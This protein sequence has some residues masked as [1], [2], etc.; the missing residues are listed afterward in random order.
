ME[1]H[2]H[3]PS[4][5]HLREPLSVTKTHEWMMGWDLLELQET[6]GGSGQCMSYSHP[7]YVALSL[8]GTG[9]SASFQETFLG[10]QFAG[11]IVK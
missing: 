6:N 7:G 5:L 11:T 1:L 8:F 4:C 10:K 9:H 3:R 2:A